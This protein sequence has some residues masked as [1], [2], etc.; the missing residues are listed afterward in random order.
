MVKLSL[1]LMNRIFDQRYW[2]H[3]INLSHLIY[4]KLYIKFTSWFIL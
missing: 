2:I 4:S 1:L 3:E